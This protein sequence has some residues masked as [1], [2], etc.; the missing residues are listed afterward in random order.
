MGSMRRSSGPASERHQAPLS[1]FARAA[2][3]GYLAMYL[4]WAGPLTGGMWARGEH[5]TPEQW[6]YHLLLSQLGFA[7]H[8]GFVPAGP[9]PEASEPALLVPPPG[10]SSLLLPALPAPPFSADSTLHQLGGAFT[11]LA[12]AAASWWRITL[13]GALREG[14]WREPPEKPPPTHP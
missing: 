6:A 4:V 13:D 2:L 5:A 8:H 7:R 12:L 11:V 3:V 14:R 10:V 9:L 1:D